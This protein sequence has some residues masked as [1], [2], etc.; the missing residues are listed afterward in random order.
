MATCGSSDVGIVLLPTSCLPD[1]RMESGMFGDHR[2]GY[3][4]MDDAN[5]MKQIILRVL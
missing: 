4:Y 1:K 3:I 2:C 5:E